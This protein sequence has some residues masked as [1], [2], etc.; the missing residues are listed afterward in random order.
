MLTIVLI[1]LVASSVLGQLQCPQCSN[2]FD[3]TSCT[4]ARTCH[5]SHDLCMLRIDVHLN[6]RVEYHCSNPN[7]CQDFA[8]TPCDPIHGQTCYF[9]CTDLD[10]CK[11]QRTALFMGILAGG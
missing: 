7:V 6:N 11:G 10:S 8:A 2:A 3:Y 9:C 1:A 4:G 5:N